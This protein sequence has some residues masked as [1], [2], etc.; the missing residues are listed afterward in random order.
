M[1]GLTILIII[2]VIASGVIIGIIASRQGYDKGIEK[3]NELTKKMYGID[4]ELKSKEC[5]VCGHIFNINKRYMYISREDEE[6]GFAANFG[7]KKEPKLYE[8]ID[9]P[10]C[11]HQNLLGVRQRGIGK[12]K[13]VVEHYKEEKEIEIMDLS[14]D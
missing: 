5:E 6:I 10:N 7:T 14:K 3:G 4:E 2:L 13:D 11:G 1:T 9:C 12:Y 8:A